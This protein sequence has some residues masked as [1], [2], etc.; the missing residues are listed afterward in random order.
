MT[1]PRPYVRS[2]RVLAA[3]LAAGT[4]LATAAC[5]GA[6][7][8]APSAS[9][10]SATVAERGLAAQT[11]SPE[12]TPAS[13]SPGTDLSETGA[14]YALIT[15][16]DIEGDWTQVDNPQEWRDSLL[17]GDVDVAAFLQGRS[18]AGDCQGLVDALYDETLLGRPSGASALTGFQEGDARLLYQVAAYDQAGLD[19]SMKWLHSL[20]DTCDQFTLTGGDDGDRTV[21]VIDLSLPDSGDDRQG[22]TVTVKGTSDGNPVTLSL[23]V[24]AVRI[25][26]SA[27]TVTNG[28]LDGADHDTTTAA[29]EQGTQ[30]LQEV[31]AGR[32]PSP[33]PSGVE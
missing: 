26:T 21:Q 6:D 19:D 20:P 24:A 12:S 1:T 4:L 28:G 22:L 8:S 11:T 29:V 16:A 13:P 32:T 14:R 30:R 31:L 33:T 23:D 17:V 3:A 25:G 5:S 18:D 9:E 15:P 7:D 10:V 27:I 2:L